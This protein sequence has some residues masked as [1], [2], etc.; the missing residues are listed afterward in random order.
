MRCLLYGLLLC[1]ASL[2]AQ[3]L[4]HTLNQLPDGATWR[5]HVAED[6]LPWW[7]QPGAYGEPLG[8]FPTF[9]CHDG[10]AYLASNPCPELLTAPTWIKAEL[11]R[12]YVRM[13]ARQVFAYAMGFHLTGDP[14][15]LKL[16][17]AGVLD[18]RQRA[19]DPKTGSAVT[20][21]QNGRGQPAVGERTVQDLAY[22]GTALAAWYY[23][24]RDAGTL[25]DLDRLHRHVMSH[26]DAKAGYLRWMQKGADAHRA[27]L[28]AQLDPLNAYM[29]LVTP[30]LRGEQQT[31]WQNDMRRLTQIIRHQFCAQGPHCQGTRNMPD[32][33][34][35]GARHNDFGHSGKSFWMSYL[36]ARQ[37]GDADTAGWARQQAQ[38]VLRE[39]Y[40]PTTGSWASRWSANGVDTGK[41]WWIYAEL[42]QLAATLALEDAGYARYLQHTWPF[43][44]QHFVD[45]QQHEVWGGVS[46]TGEHRAGE[47]KQHQWK[48]GYHAMEHALISYLAAQAL[49]GQPATLYFAFKPDANSRI[50]PYLFQAKASSQQFARRDD[51]PML[52]VDFSW[53]K[54]NLASDIEL[55]TAQPLPP[56][57]PIVVEHPVALSADNAQLLVGDWEGEWR[58]ASIPASG[59]LTFNISAVQEQHLVGVSSAYSTPDDNKNLN[60]ARQDPIKFANGH[61][62]LSNMRGE[63][64]Q[65]EAVLAEDDGEWLLQ[66]KDR[67]G[68]QEILFSLRKPITH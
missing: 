17:Q 14:A 60:V 47:L 68:D 64:L 51:I 31:R 50:Q 26:F 27:E 42:D 29:M 52:R 61:L 15:L 23:L 30:L 53:P 8:R 56:L 35:A 44:L 66:W 24:T 9:R 40:V 43:W 10:S 16:A 3:P 62:W 5:Q 11:G 37:I 25:A 57:S 18:I 59:R 65:S 13:Q 49:H 41:S 39:A 6:L 63:A 28:V 38:A 12:D 32:S 33:D 34:Q 20:Y 36:A 1:S 7:Q 46:S 48:N 19:L 4:E 58:I 55:P 54:P 22:A 45:H 2:L 67:V 21:W